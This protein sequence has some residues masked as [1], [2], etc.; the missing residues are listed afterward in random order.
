[1]HTQSRLFVAIDSLSIIKPWEVRQILEA[2][3]PLNTHHPPGNYAIL[4]VHESYFPI[5]RLEDEA[6]FEATQAQADKIFRHYDDVMQCVIVVRTKTWILTAKNKPGL[7]Q[8]ERAIGY[9]RS[10][11]TLM[12]V[13]NDM[14]KLGK[15]VQFYPNHPIHKP[16]LLTTLINFVLF[17]LA[18]QYADEP[19]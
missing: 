2:Y 16:I 9:T 18:Q 15:T 8:V 17:T 6:L 5:Q 10:G 13:L 3:R 12:I 7:M 14:E 4:P 19:A 11:Q 1:M